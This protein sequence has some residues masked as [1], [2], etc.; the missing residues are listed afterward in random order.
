MQTEHRKCTA[1]RPDRVLAVDDDPVVLTLIENALKQAGYEPYLAIDGLDAV[2]QFEQV[3][4]NIVVM[5]VRMPNLNGFD[6]CRRIRQLPEGRLVPILMLTA[7]DDVVSVETAFDA[8][9]TDFITKPINWPL[10]S[11]RLRYALRTA[12]RDQQMAMTTALLRQAQRSTQVCHW[13]RP[14]GTNEIIWGDGVSEILRIEEAQTAMSSAVVV[15]M[16]P[17]DRQNFESHLE[18]WGDGNTQSTCEFR[19]NCDDGTTRTY[20]GVATLIKDECGGYNGTLGTVQDISDL[21]SSQAQ[22]VQASKLASLGEMAT[23]VA[24]EL[25]QPLNI[26]RMGAGNFRRRFEAGLLDDGYIARQLGRI[27]EQTSRAAKIIDHM[28]SFGREAKED[29]TE[30]DIVAVVNN[31]IELLKEELRLDNVRVDARFGPSLAYVR[32]HEIQLEQVLVNLMLNA[33]DAM[34]EVEDRQKVLS[35]RVNVQ[36]SDVVIECEDTGK[37]F[38]ARLDTSRLFEPFFTTDS[39]DHL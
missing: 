38:D 8:G 6:A 35:L 17:A 10:L 36:G 26:I 14:E 20:L 31:A 29:M 32:G 9:A 39:I 18:P 11:H 34:Y 4:P 3:Q 16:N 28:Q 27:E 25:N 5:D 22:L 2:A 13:L 1:K 23:A 19:L 37:G 24:H 33:R 7:L 30:I 12:Y 21:R 15:R